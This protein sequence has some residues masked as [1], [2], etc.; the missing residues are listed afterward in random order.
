MYDTLILSGGGVKGLIYIGFIK[1]LEDNKILD[2]IKNVY[3]TSIGSLICLLINLNY[4]SSELINLVLNTNFELLYNLKIQNLFDNELYGLDNLNHLD[5]FLNFILSYKNIDKDITFS[6]LFEKTNINF[7]CIAT[8]LFNFEETFM[9]HT[10]TPNV[11]IKDA[12]LS[13]CALPIIFTKYYI[14]E[15]DTHYID[16][17][18]TNNFPIEYATTENKVLGVYI[19]NANN[20]KNIIPN[21]F[22][23]YCISILKGVHS[24]Y[25]CYQQEKVK[26]YPDS[27]IINI[28]ISNLCS[29]V[30]FKILE[31]DKKKLIK[32]GYNLI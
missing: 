12:I 7:G 9:N 30:N 26:L 32:I 6:S 16:G 23:E 1:K 13:S 8:K 24:K 28:D 18:F 31:N 17:G 21:N 3:G 2:N 19:I 14:K 20:L 29:T 4:T 5:N 15:L 27:K 22:I 25:S 10:T 11:K